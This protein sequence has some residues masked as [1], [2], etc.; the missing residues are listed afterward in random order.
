MYFGING[1]KSKSWIVFSIVKAPGE[2]P[3]TSEVARSAPKP[4]ETAAA[5]ALDSLEAVAA[6]VQEYVQMERDDI[7]SVQV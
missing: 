4:T 2:G 5:D 7:F 1:N 6:G 3:F